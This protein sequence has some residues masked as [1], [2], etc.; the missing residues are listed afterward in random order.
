MSGGGCVQ[1][2]TTVAN[3]GRTPA[4]RAVDET[5]EDAAATGDEGDGGAALICGDDEDEEAACC[6]VDVR[7][8]VMINRSRSEA[9]YRF[10][11]D[12]IAF[13]NLAHL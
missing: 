2:R 6:A 3:D 9:R 5:G 12:M 13:P 8:L 4:E 7:G 10:W 11:K 1:P